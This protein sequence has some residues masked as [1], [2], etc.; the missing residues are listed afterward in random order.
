MVEVDSTEADDGAEGA[1]PWE[2][3]E[4]QWQFGIGLELQAV[5]A[6][7]FLV[8]VDHERTDEAD[9]VVAK[10]PAG[11]IAIGGAGEGPSAEDE[12]IA[13][14]VQEL[15]DGWPLVFREGGGIGKNEEMG[16]GCGE[17]IAEVVGVSGL[18]GG[19]AWRHGGS[20]EESAIGKPASMNTTEEH[21]CAGSAVW[22]E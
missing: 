21:A 4:L 15:L 2:R 18:R 7:S 3:G 12:E 17:S 5:G 1:L 6:G 9:A 19:E 11:R 20:A 10:M 13:A 16:C 14:A 8:L 22:P